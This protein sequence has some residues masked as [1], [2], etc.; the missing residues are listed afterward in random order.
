MPGNLAK[1]HRRPAGRPCHGPDQ[2][3]TGGTPALLDERRVPS[4]LV[5][6]I[7]IEAGPVERQEGAAA[8]LTALEGE[9]EV[10]RLGEENFAAAAKDALPSSCR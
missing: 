2:E 4:Q 10:R 9:V 1:E 5:T 8:K 6:R 3:I 7:G